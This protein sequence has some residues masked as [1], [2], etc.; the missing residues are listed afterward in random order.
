MK[1]RKNCGVVK[2]L[3][4]ATPPMVYPH[5]HKGSWLSESDRYYEC[6]H[7]LLRDLESLSSEIVSKW[8]IAFSEAISN[9]DHHPD[10]AM[11]VKRRDVLS[12]SVRIFSAMTI[13]AFLN[14]YGVVRLGEV[15]YEKNLGREF[16]VPKLIKVLH[17]C[18]N[19]TIQETD[20]LAVLVDRIAKG[21]N[22]LVHPKSK[23]IFG[24]FS[25]TNHNGTGI[26]GFAQEMVAD[27]RKFFCIFV[28][29][30]P[31]SKHLIPV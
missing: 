22:D 9:S 4:K 15:W 14:F 1:N 7:F 3:T 23:A 11:L 6:V 8:P 2:K 24:K 19:I 31:N 25:N 28:A 27:M 13:E 16:I 17:F 18:D 10:L 29:L 20:E 12:D 26:P 5:D 30:V 21:R